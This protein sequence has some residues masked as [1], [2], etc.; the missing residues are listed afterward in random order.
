MTYATAT[1]LATLTGSTLPTA[2]LT[3]ILDEADRQIKSRLALAEVSPPATDDKLKSAC[4]SLARIGLIM[5]GTPDKLDNITI[6]ELREDAFASIDSYTLASA[7]DRYRWS[8]R[9]VNA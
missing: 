3:A 4:L 1:E 2:T 7:T 5:W 8:I 9:K 6:T